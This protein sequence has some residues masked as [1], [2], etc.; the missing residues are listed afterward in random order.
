MVQCQAGYILGA[1]KDAFLSFDANNEMRPLSKGL[2]E[3]LSTFDVAGLEPP[4]QI[5]IH[6][7]L[8]VLN[9]II[10]RG[11][12]TLVSEQVEQYFAEHLQLTE[13]RYKHGA[14]QFP[15]VGGD[16]LDQ[17]RKDLFQAMHL[18]DP[19]VTNRQEYV[20][21]TDLDSSFERSFVLQLITQAQSFLAQLFQHQRSRATLARTD[22]RGRV[23]FSL[24]IPYFRIS[25]R[26]NRYNQEVQ[27]KCRP[28]YVVE[29]DGSAY[30][31][32]LIDDLKDFEIGQFPNNSTHI[33]EGSAFRDAQ[34]LLQSLSSEPFLQAVEENY[35]SQE[36]LGN[37]LTALVLSPFL[38]ARIQKALL[39]YLILNQH[40][41][42][43]R[44][45]IRLAVVE[46]DIPAAY[47][48]VQ[49]F[50]DH[51]E[52]LNALAG[53]P[54]VVP[55]IQVS[56]FATPEFIRHPLHGKNAPTSLEEC[57]PS[58]YDLVL[59]VSMLRRSGIFADD[60]RFNSA[61][62]WVIRSSHFTDHRQH[63]SIYCAESIAYLPVSKEIENEVHEEIPETTT[64]LRYF[65]RNIFRKEDFRE[66][67]LPILN[68]ALQRKSVIG[69]LPTG[70]G[71]SLTYQLAAILQPGIT[72]VVDPI[73]SL[74]VDQF[75]GLKEI[76]I[77]RCE[78]INSTLSG[79]E[80]RFNQNKLLPEGQ[81]QFIFVSPERFVIQEFRD[82]LATTATSHFFFSYVVIDEVHCVSEWGHDFRTPY[83]NL[84]LHGVKY[85]KTANEQ[86]IPL[87][88]LTATASFDVL[89]DIERELQIPDD[90]GNAV[91][92]YE[93][94]IRDEINYAVEEVSV[95][96]AGISN[97]TTAGVKRMIG[98]AKQVAVSGVLR[99]KEDKLRQFNKDEVIRRIAT[100]SWDNYVSPG[101]KSRMAAQFGSEAE[102]LNNYVSRQ[103]VSLRLESSVFQE[104]TVVET[105]RR[106]TY[107]AVVFTPH[108]IGALGIMHGGLLDHDFVENHL[109]GPPTFGTES[110]G[111]FMGSGDDENAA[112]IDEA[113][114]KNL[115]AFIKNEL[116]V[117]VATKAFGMGIDKPNVR[118]TIHLNIPQSI[119]SFVQEAGRAGRD[120]RL[121]YS[122]ILF[123]QQLLPVQDGNRR[124][125]D[126]HLDKD[127]LMYFHRNSFK[128]QIKE[129]AMIHELRTQVTFPNLTNQQRIAQLLEEL[130]GAGQYHFKVKKGSN[131]WS[132]Y[133][134]VS[135]ITE[136]QNVGN[137]NLSNRSI[138]T[139]NGFTDSTTCREIMQ[140][141]LGELPQGINNSEEVGRWLLQLTVNTRG[142]T[143]IERMLE[144]M[145]MGAT[146]Q[147]QVP[148]T[149]RYYT[150]PARPGED[151]HLNAA[152]VELIQRTQTYTELIQQNHVTA[153]TFLSALITANRNGETF[154][155]FIDRLE[156]RSQELVAQLKSKDPIDRLHITY[157]K[158][159]SQDDTAKAIYRLISIGVID[160]YT[161]DYQNKLYTLQFTKKQPGAYFEAF[162]QLMARYTS[163]RVASRKIEEL[164]A[165]F[166]GLPEGRA[167]VLSFCLEKLTNFI[168]EKIREKR[169]QAIEDMLSLCRNAV[170]L[171]ADPL[172]Q[173]EYLKD[174]IY[175]YFNAKYS[176]VDFTE[177]ATGEEASLY[178]DRETNLTIQQQIDKYIR[179]TEDERTG[180]FLNNIKHL[181]GSTMRMLRSE[182]DDPAYLVLK[183]F[184]LLVLSTVISSLLGEAKQELVKGM[185]RWKQQE[186]AF[187][188]I[189]FIK[190]FREKVAEHVYDHILQDAFIDIEDLYYTRY[191]VE[192]TKKL[193]TEKL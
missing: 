20:N 43:E 1:V 70:G 96:L 107:G 30:H 126:F 15:F 93:N 38:I 100:Y 147:L 46:R 191:Y 14:I 36:W 32:E 144:N 153:G 62:T 59:D 130:Y 76:G 13:P 193:I 163:R 149:N 119:E 24:E 128:G 148:F 26:N 74:M 5:P 42:N 164:R 79:A 48:A 161:I 104:P 137:I 176:R 17:R 9:N 29:V 178:N 69:L 86:N 92:R 12:P 125:A 173:S 187:N 185:I 11:K 131:Q 105:S 150:A 167:T 175:Y 177:P 154:D 114:F 132:G 41:L 106:Y 95:N 47:I 141:V 34:A 31:N 189:L 72:I 85:C 25:G 21:L 112:A 183:A 71:K 16:E 88:G 39:E 94:T 90:D 65:L 109:D 63:N 27:V 170:S 151:Y 143:G 156:M 118:L 190:A 120:K 97:F 139:Y 134:F 116:S 91:V 159:R 127:V 61:H 184:S 52:K 160:A 83:L 108:R 142:E 50:I 87:F 57:D 80:K 169:L 188:P 168:Y 110:V 53:S 54:L 6:P 140:V 99:N 56:V 133:V 172:R 115:D 111:Y 40:S 75:R 45:V 73:R 19:R 2:V 165:E 192:W 68:R 171:S 37:N 66:G 8:A 55:D 124:I 35:R 89:A 166:D 44:R 64:L 121:S 162:E 3:N 23:D 58:Q 77:D 33:R 145:E 138:R 157:Y 174:E 123:N 60:G 186:R 22:N 28:R 182:G 81:L 136:D 78:F 98:G 51:I 10:T 179:L 103:Q 155:E 181:R 135:E 7:V 102:A 129:R 158:G 122:L 82:A 4:P 101:Y 146:A 180:Q 67:Q 49:D 152:Y 113:S 18:V 84:G 117:M